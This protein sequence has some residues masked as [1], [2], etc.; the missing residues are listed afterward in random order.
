[1]GLAA[2]GAVLGIWLLYR[3]DPRIRTGFYLAVF[4]CVA[5]RIAMGRLQ[6]MQVNWLDVVMAASFALGL[7]LEV[8][9]MLN[10]K[11]KED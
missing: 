1:L 11:R 7:V 10:R 3:P 2:I 9:S 6:G 8:A 5:I 4:G